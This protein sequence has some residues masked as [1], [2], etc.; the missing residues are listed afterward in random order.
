[1]N[2]WC[3]L[4]TVVMLSLL[5]VKVSANFTAHDAYQV[6]QEM[7]TQQGGFIEAS[8][9]VDTIN[10]VLLSEP[11][12]GAKDSLGIWKITSSWL[13]LSQQNDGTVKISMPSIIANEHSFLGVHQ[14]V[15]SFIVAGFQ[16]VMSRTEEGVL[17][18]VSGDEL[19][20][21]SRFEIN[22]DSLIASERHWQTLLQQW[23]AEIQ[24]GA[25][26]H[27]VK[28]KLATK[29]LTLA[30]F[31]DNGLDILRGQ[32][33]QLRARYS[34]A[35]SNILDL[36]STPF[37]EDW[38]GT[39]LSF[40]SGGVRYTSN[41]GQFVDF[42]SSAFSGSLNSRPRQI[43][44]TLSGQGLNLQTRLDGQVQD[45]FQINHLD[46]Q[47]E[48]IVDDQSTKIN[49]NTDVS[50][51]E[52][53]RHLLEPRNQSSEEGLFPPGRLDLNGS[54]TL[55]NARAQ[56]FFGGQWPDFRPLEFVDWKV[57]NSQLNFLG[58]TL[59]VSG[60]VRQLFSEDGQEKWRLIGQ[61]VAFIEGLKGALKTIKTF[62]TLNRTGQLALRMVS[63][64][65]RKVSMDRLRYDVE[66]H[67]DGSL[68]VNNFTFQ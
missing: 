51:V 12:I 25:A 36:I 67:E 68:T 9:V 59:D 46:W 38:F 11:R 63:M 22:D 18:S 4:T 8:E 15:G 20:N 50:E 60:Q 45:A 23:R 48:I 47:H 61:G 55:S 64:A 33:E 29:H 31:D 17:I 14:S 34:G 53:N 24:F 41:P 40:A 30:L 2:L 54:L 43:D 37:S 21:V 65:G 1:M 66:F 58:T 49:V 10:S 42:H 5:P 52:I 32:F 39:S 28:A 26:Q 7:I 57:E 19:Q 3:S 6:L 56:E 35:F 16:G 62:S 27:S 44:T 13:R